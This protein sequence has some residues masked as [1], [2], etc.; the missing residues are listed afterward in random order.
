[1]AAEMATCVIRTDN[2]PKTPFAN[3]QFGPGFPQPSGIVIG[4]RY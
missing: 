1:L 2:L 3:C 4:G